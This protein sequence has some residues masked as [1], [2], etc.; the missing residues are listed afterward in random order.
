MTGL[1]E[2]RNDRVI[3]SADGKAALWTG[4]IDDLWQLGKPR[5][6][7]G[8]WKDTPVQANAPSDP[9]LMTGYDKKTLTLSATSG[10]TITVEVDVDG[11]GLWVPYKT[12]EV[13]PNG[14]VTH[15]FPTGFSAYWV[16]TISDAQTTATAQLTYN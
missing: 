12:F 15:V 16:R 6:Q 14:P 7:G 10:T 1:N 8:P 3:A 2:Q 13:K 9:Y 11:T 4:V 5:G